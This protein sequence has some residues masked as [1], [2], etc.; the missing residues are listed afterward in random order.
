MSDCPCKSKKDY[1][2]CCKPF[3]LGQLPSSAL[4]LMR[5]R[6]SA[7]ALS[8]ADYIINTTDPKGP[9][10]VKDL[11]KWKEEILYFSK[12]TQFVDLQILSFT[13][14]SE[15]RAT[16]TFIATLRQKNQEISFQ[17]KSLFIKKEGKWLYSHPI[18]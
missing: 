12:S 15:S 2:S 4:E 13:E 14:E 3:H 6:F 18:Q 11:K 1:Q 17:E 10:F 5:S 9:L 7:Y 8:N 16:V